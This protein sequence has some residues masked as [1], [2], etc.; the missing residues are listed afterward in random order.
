MI[1][2][3]HCRGCHDDYYNGPNGL[4]GICWSRKD[5]K[6]VWRVEI[7]I[8]QCPPYDQPAKRFPDCY[9][10]QRYVYYTREQAR[11]RA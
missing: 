1:D 7:S 2:R 11:S 8:D 4:D 5:A 10:R 3:K 9:H 6:I